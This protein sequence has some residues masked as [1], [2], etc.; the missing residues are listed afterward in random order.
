MA[1]KDIRVGVVGCG[2]IS[3]A[4]IVG[5]KGFDGAELVAVCDIDE[6][7][8]QAK[9]EEHGALKW[10]TDYR[11]LFGS[12]EINAVSICSSSLTHAEI[13]IA[14]AESGI[15]ILCEKPMGQ[16]LKQCDDMIRAAKENNVVYSGVYQNR[17]SPCAQRIKQLINTGKMGV[18]ILVKGYTWTTHI[19]D[20]TQWLL[21]PPVRISAEWFGQQRVGADPLIATVMFQDGNIGIAQAARGLFEPP[22]LE[23][24]PW[25]ISVLGGRLSAYFMLFSDKMRL[26]SQ[27]EE[28]LGEAEASIQNAFPGRFEGH[29]PNVHDF[30]NAIVEDRDPHITGAEA[31]KAIE[32]MIGC[33][34]AAITHEPTTLPIDL[35]D[36]FY[37]STARRVPD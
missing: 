6:A 19:F 10:Y 4:H 25:V 28:W 29:T 26:E 12:G 20:I 30:L 1:G 5:Y 17:F 31:R 27:N 7:K 34:R 8:A 13:A 14:A 33:Y 24:N 15:H 37:A 35:S 36:E 2:R 18:P 9:A 23:G 16:S 11:K 22:I 21:A 32:F 3:N